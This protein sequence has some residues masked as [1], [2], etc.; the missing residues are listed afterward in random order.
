MF[1]TSSN[2]R[3]RTIA[4]EHC[5]YC[6]HI[7]VCEMEFPPFSHTRA[8]ARNP[9]K[10][11]GNICVSLFKESSLISQISLT[12]TAERLLTESVG[13]YKC[14]IFHTHFNISIVVVKVE[15]NSFIYS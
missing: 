2:L 1:S 9:L 10:V 8:E 12:R 14:I 3:I 7:L 11:S 13:F 6:N 5:A 4:T 15:I